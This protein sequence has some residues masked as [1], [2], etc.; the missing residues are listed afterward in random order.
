MEV[1]FLASLDHS[2]GISDPAYIAWLRFIGKLSSAFAQTKLAQ[3][4]SIAPADYPFTFESSH[5]PLADDINTGNYRARSSSPQHCRRPGGTDSYSNLAVSHEY[6][7][8]ST[9]DLAAQHDLAVPTGASKKRSAAE[10]LQQEPI[11]TVRRMRSAQDAG[12]QPSGRRLF[13]NKYHPTPSIR[14]VHSDRWQD[15]RVNEVTSVPPPSLA[16]YPAPTNFTA[17]NTL[18]LDDMYNTNINMPS[19]QSNNDMAYLQLPYNYRLGLQPR[20]EVSRVDDVLQ[21]SFLIRNYAPFQDLTFYTLAASPVQDEYLYQ[22]NFQD[23]HV[24]RVGKPRIQKH[25]QPQPLVAPAGQIPNQY[26]MPQPYPQQMQLMP[27]LYWPSQQDAPRRSSAPNVFP[28]HAVQYA[29]NSAS[30]QASSISPL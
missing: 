5:L 24:A 14:S 21:S 29:L 6:A 3:Q 20:A 11:Q 16:Y 15:G 4:Y 1:E 18:F 2:V 30:K 26:I 19:S 10:A 7:P 23:D 17:D 28:S 12:R 22:Q 13:P 8:Y 27:H 9:E 25:G